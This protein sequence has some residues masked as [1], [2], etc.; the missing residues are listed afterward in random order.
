MST[1]REYTIGW[2]DRTLELGRK[3]C[4]M[5]VVNV[6][7]DSFSDGGRFF[8]TKQAVAHGLQL[9]QEGAGILDIGGESTRPNAD[10]VPAADEIARVV[11][12]IEALAKKVS[13]PISIDTTKAEV[14]RRALDAGATII[15]DVGALRLDPQMVAVVAEYGVPVILMHMQG[16]PRTMQQNPRYDNLLTEIASFL[17]TA[18]DRAVAGGVRRS[19]IIVD[20]GIG[21]GKT[22]AHNLSLIK[23]TK[24]LKSLDVPVLM[25]AS[26][27]SFIQKILNRAMETP[28]RPDLDVVETGSQ[29]AVAAAVLNGA[30]IVRVHDVKNSVVTA[31]IIDAVQSAD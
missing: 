11:P 12:V 27:K 14:A 24:T 1:R 20:P 18:I 3:T 19:R 29:A 2:G 30:H 28:L 15:N 4:V 5:G 6:T 21:F 31:S 23:H 10:E 8:E 26:R 7:P 17:A 22:V 16:S 13:V 25:G 9:V